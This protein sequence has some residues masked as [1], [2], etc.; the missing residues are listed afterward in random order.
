MTI[1][2]L[3]SITIMHRYILQKQKDIY[4]V[5][6]WHQALKPRRKIFYFTS[7]VVSRNIYI[8]VTVIVQY[9][10]NTCTG[11]FGIRFLHVLHKSKLG[12][13]LH[14]EKGLNDT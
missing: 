6:S 14:F 2:H 13:L 1:E 8:A 4:S 11:V 12:C 3:N 7:S 9:A 5:K 10:Q